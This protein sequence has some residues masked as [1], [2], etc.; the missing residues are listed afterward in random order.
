MPA[1]HLDMDLSCVTAFADGRAEY[2]YFGN[3][4]CTGAKHSGDIRSI[5]PMVGTAEYI[6]LSL[7]ELEAANARY[8]TFSCNAYSRG[9][10]SPNLV[11]GWMSSEKPMQ[12]SKRTGVAYDPSCVQQMI[13]I[14]ENNLSK[15]LIFGVLDVPKREITW[16]EMPFTSQVIHA[17]DMTSVE[18]LLRKLAAKVSVGELLKLKAKAQKLISIATASEADE[19]YTYEWAIT[20]GNINSLLN[21]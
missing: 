15:G 8:V 20:P 9:S 12:I 11:V 17:A 5:P 13:R 19:A 18:A 21:I 1:Q 16:L 4:T 14:S 10:L 3:L 7:S 6:E 2:C